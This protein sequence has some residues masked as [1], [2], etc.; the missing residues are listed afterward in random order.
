MTVEAEEVKEGRATVILYHVKAVHG[1]TEFESEIYADERIPS[2]IMPGIN[3]ELVKAA[4]TGK[5]ISEDIA[6]EIALNGGKAYYTVLYCTLDE[7]GELPVYKVVTY[8]LT[9]A[10]LTTKVISAESGMVLEIK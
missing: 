2:V 3:F 1:V 7:S 6:K 4:K 10:N 5:Y 9:G 8:S